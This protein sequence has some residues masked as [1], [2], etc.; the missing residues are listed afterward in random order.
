MKK[1]I[2]ILRTTIVGGVFF[3]VPFVAL[4]IV[5]NKAIQ[6]VR[7]ITVPLAERLPFESIIG[8]EIP[9]ILAVV[10]LLFFCLFAGLFATTSLAKKLVNWLESVLLSNIPGYSFLK[11][12][13]EEA[14]GTAP[15]H[16]QQA[17]IVQFDDASQIGILVEH[18]SGGRVAVFIPDAPNPLAG[19]VFILDKD[20]VTP[21]EVPSASA[22][23]CLQR[24]GEGTGV[25]VNKVRSDNKEPS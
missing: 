1:L 19:G 6:I 17:V 7:V 23:K 3:L 5:I 8:L 20:R 15:E 10:V 12:L 14:V 9:K 16:G 4:I 25:L 13:G 21:L 18:I 2:R 24:L 11:N 22:L